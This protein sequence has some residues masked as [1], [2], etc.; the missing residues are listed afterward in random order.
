MQD[1]NLIKVASQEMQNIFYDI[2]LK[3]GCS[4][5]QALQCAELFTNNSV[6]GVYTHGVNRFPRFV[7]YIQKGF[8]DIKATPALK[9]AFGGIQQWDGHLGIGP[10][11]A[12]HA[13]S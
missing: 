10:L 2:L 5:E 4:N 12:I 6:D 9:H 8:I 3:Q 7:E 11:N 13:T 1:A